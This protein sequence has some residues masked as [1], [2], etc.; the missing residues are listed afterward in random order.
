MWP[1]CCSKGGVRWGRRRISPSRVCCSFASQQVCCGTTSGGRPMPCTS[2]CSS[3]TKAGKSASA[4]SK[5]LNQGS[6]VAR[7]SRTMAVYSASYSSAGLTSCSPLQSIILHD[8]V[9][10]FGRDR[11]PQNRPYSVAAVR[12]VEAEVF[13]GEACDDATA[14]GA[15]DEAEL[16]QVGFV[17][18]LDGFG[19]F[20][21]AGGQRVQADG[22][23]IELLDDGQ[24]QVAVGLVEADLVD[25][26]RCQG[27]LSH[28]ACDDAVGAHL[29]IVAHALEQ[30]VD[31]T[32]GA[33]RAACD[34]FNALF[35][36]RD[37]EDARRTGQDLFERGSLVVLHAVNS[38]EAVA[39][40]GGERADARGGSYDGECWQAETQ[41]T[42]ARPF[43][44]HHIQR[45][46]FHRRIQALL[47]GAAQAVDFVDEQHFARLQ[48]RQDRGQVARVFDGRA[49]GGAQADTHLNSDDVTER[50]FAQPR[51]AVQQD[52]IDRFVALARRFQQ[53]AQIILDLL[54]PDIFRQAARA[55][56][57]LDGLLFFTHLR[58]DEAVAHMLLLLLK[59]VFYNF[60]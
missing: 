30:A 18:I 24:Q 51:R 13:V 3:C 60:L 22:A 38:P 23:T 31:D 19:V 33:A 4:S 52:V 28:L 59:L 5:L 44:D 21:G 57:A 46:I 55:Q 8:P 58:R 32:R 35:I 49:R 27:R 12:G 47:D 10:F 43:A 7:N 54:L 15:C 39:Q 17:D 45:E 26:Q 11:L 41:G 29:G 1:L 40:R 34:L 20:T 9:L 53:D 50:G 6:P 48:G 14:W 16:Q 37:F 56:T 25:L 42:R 2:S 36:G